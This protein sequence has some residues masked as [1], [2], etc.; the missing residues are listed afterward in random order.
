MDDR[1][2][3]S[4]PAS[5]AS[6]PAASAPPTAPTPAPSAA[7]PPPSFAPPVTGAA[8]P[9]PRKKRG[10]LA[11]CLIALVVAVLLV[12]GGVFAIT[13]LAKPADLG[14]AYSE[15]DFDAVIAKVGVAWPELPEGANPDDYQ[16]VYSGE[17]PLDVVLTEAELSALMSYN[18]NASYWPVQSMQ[19]NLTGGNTAEVSAVVTYAGRDWPVLASGSGTISRKTLDVSIGSAEVIGISVPA[20]YLPYG[21]AFLEAMVND[22]L[23]R[24]EGL[25]IDSIEITEEGVHLVGTTWATA[26]Y[27]P[28]Q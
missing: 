12:V 17:Q 28:V 13:Q 22:R 8:A 20:E 18:H 10:C 9:A 21:E 6:A 15:A 4:T 25:N 3:G 5:V 7:P 1:T 23:A 24:I 27:V 11:G 14:V 2:P 19:V 16:R 26:E